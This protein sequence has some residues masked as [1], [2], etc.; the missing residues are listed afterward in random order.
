MTLQ[1]LFRS[2]SQQPGPFALVLMCIPLLALLV[3]L[4]SGRTPEE[5]L[6]W[7]YAYTVLVYAAAIPGVFAFTLNIYLFLFERQSVWTMNLITQVLPMISMGATLWMIRQKI[8]FSY[9]PGFGKLSGFLTLIAALIG[10]LFFLDR[11]HFYAVT[12]VPFVYLLVGFVGVLLLIR[13]A[14]SRLF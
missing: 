6:R 10:T 14:W 2:V 8:P 1:D 11:L 9:V 3:N 13:F 12:Y 7:K 4:W 5:I